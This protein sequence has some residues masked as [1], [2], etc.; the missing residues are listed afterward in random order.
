MEVSMVRPTE[1]APPTHPMIAPALAGFRLAA[2]LTGL[3]ALGVLV[4]AGCNDTISVPVRNQPPGVAITGGI[5]QVPPDRGTKDSV[6][7]AAEILW[8]GWDPDGV[9]DHYQ[10]VIDVPDELLDRVHDPEDYGIAWRDTVAFRANF[11]FRTDEQDSLLGEPIPRFRGDH[12]FYVRAVDNEGGVSR[13]DYVNFTAVNFSPRTTITSPPGAATGNVLNIGKAFNFCWEGFDPDSPDPR[14]QPVAYEWKLKQMPKDWNPSGRDAQFCVDVLA[15]DIP[16]YRQSA[17]TTCQHFS[18]QTGHPYILA[19]RAIDE[20]GAVETRFVMGQN[21]VILDSSAGNPTS[22]ILVV[23]S[24]ELGRVVF[25]GPIVEMEVALGKCL[26]FNLHGDARGYGGELQGYEWGL[27]VDPDGTEGF[28]GIT[29]MERT[30]PVCLETP[31]L[32]T[33][34]L[35]C[36]DTGGGVT[37]GILY[38][39]AIPLTFGKEMVYIDDFRRVISQG[40]RDADQD[41]R[42]REMLAAAGIPVDDPTQFRQIDLWGP[43]DDQTDPTQ[44]RLS[45]IADYKMVYWD[46]LGTG[47]S[48]NPALVAANACP[49]SKI[50]Q[51]YVGAGGALWVSG[52]TVFAAFDT[53]NGGGCLANINYGWGEENDGL[54]FGPGDF[55]NDYMNVVNGAFKNV[56]NNSVVNGF[57][58]AEPEPGIVT[59]G[60]PTLAV[61]RGVFRP[62]GGI[63][64]CD[65]ASTIQVDPT[66]GLETMYTHVAA[67]PNSGT[68]GR[69]NAL[70]YRDP[71]AVPDQGPLA[72]FGFPVFF[73]EQGSESG[74]GSFEMARLM[75]QWLKGEQQRYFDTHPPRTSP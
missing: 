65:V 52:M 42:N 59:L 3:V 24:P 14:R 67:M 13:A 38:I 36:R 75:I 40:F 63:N 43:N 4:V 12:T 16:W 10:Y 26:Y 32:H 68:N 41:R 22:P 46:V 73:L 6:S 1:S 28:S 20:A 33:L 30:G 69:V 5:V 50:L 39:R 61:D 25:P 45:D 7:Y 9:V 72:V 21:T 44:L 29:K 37:D 60:F 35:R 31:G 51:A 71:A 23:T 34:V 27:D 55:L 74:T 11:T 2:A 18:L 19:V 54:N 57:V 56:R 53:A 47:L 8:A 62:S 58:R 48:R 64:A 17:D 15:A 70:R 66:G 49:T